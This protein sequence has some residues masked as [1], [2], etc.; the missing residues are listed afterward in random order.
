MQWIHRRNLVLGA[1]T[2]LVLAACDKGTEV[3]EQAAGVAEATPPAV[4][5][6]QAEPSKTSPAPSAREYTMED[7]L[8]LRD[9]DNPACKALEL[10][11]LD[12][13]LE[14]EFAG[15][16]FTGELADLNRNPPG[17]IGY[18]HYLRRGR[19]GHLSLRMW[20]SG[21]QE[22]SRITTWQASDSLE[23]APDIAKRAFRVRWDDESIMTTC[24][25]LGDAI[26]CFSGSAPSV[27]RI[28]APADAKIMQLLA[29]ALKR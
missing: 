7:L 18:C 19:P 21:D 22:W 13:H 26:A 14:G 2:T 20:K 23:E 12:D 4:R 28:W 27:W 8:A 16:P 11:W 9:A 3:D 17:L 1:L 29:N 24:A 15:M 10:S 5:E 25:D 6:P